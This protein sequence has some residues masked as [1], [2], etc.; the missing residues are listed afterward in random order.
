ME[1]AINK[2]ADKMTWPVDTMADAI[3]AGMMHKVGTVAELKTLYRP[4]CM[5]STLS[6]LIFL[7]FIMAECPICQIQRPMLVPNMDAYSSSWRITGHL[8]MRTTLVCSHPRRASSLS[9]QG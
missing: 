6:R 4:N 2:Q 9:S 3:S 5:D 7:S 8:V 1:E